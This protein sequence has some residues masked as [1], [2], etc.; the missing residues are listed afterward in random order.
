[1]L[2]VYVYSNYRSLKKLYEAVSNILTPNDVHDLYRKINMNFKEVLRERIVT[3]NI[4]NNG[5]P[6]HGYVSRR[7]FSLSAKSV[8]KFPCS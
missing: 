1:M 7:L 4:V 5:G 2:I 3:M 8:F 6:Q